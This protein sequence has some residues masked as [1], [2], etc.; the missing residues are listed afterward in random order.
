[1]LDHHP[2]LCK[3]EKFGLYLVGWDGLVEQDI[4]ELDEN[5]EPHLAI[6]LTVGSSLE[7]EWTVVA[8]N[9]DPKFISSRDREL[10]AFSR[11]GDFVDRHITWARGSALARM[12]DGAAS[13]REVLAEAQ[14]QAVKAVKNLE[15]TTLHESAE[16]IEELSKLLGV[17]PREKFTPGLDARSIGEGTA[18]LSLH[19]GDVPLR[20]CGVG[21]RR[22]IAAAIQRQ[23]LRE[24]GA[25][26]VDEIEHGL[27]PHR[28]IHLIRTLLP[29]HGE[30]GPQVFITTHSSTVVAEVG[31]TGVCIVRNS[32]GQVTVTPIPAT[33]A[34]AGLVRSQPNAILARKVIVCEGKTEGGL[35]W[36]LDDTRQEANDL[37]FSILGLVPVDGG[38]RTRAPNIAIQLSSLGFS[39]AYFGDSDEP[40]VPDC[41]EMTSAGVRVFLWPGKVCTEKRLFLDVPVESLQ[42]LYDLACELNDEEVC[43]RQ[44]QGTLGN[45]FNGEVDT[46]INAHS[47]DELRHRLAHAASPKEQQRK[48]W[49]K[50]WDKGRSL[51]K[52]VLSQRCALSAPSRETFDDLDA[53]IDGS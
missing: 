41:D 19:D 16:K 38:G 22:L 21:T 4:R 33:E 14:R 29:K 2:P 50:R 23:S 7:P 13:L 11:L 3:E 17:M 52:L 47:E 12:G 34:T 27:E 40:P 43:L 20:L 39:V 45:D 1:M 6:Q 32:D 53:W 48:A 36:A 30:P 31:A 25:I 44:A 51:G 15:G 35:M 42:S 24:G 5:D 26:L 28:L 9:R 49:F 18:F 37:C 46:W 8:P 10:I